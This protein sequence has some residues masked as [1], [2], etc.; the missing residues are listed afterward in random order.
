MPD[1][2]SQQDLP[3]TVCVH[4]A[5]HEMVEYLD[6]PRRPHTFCA[7]LR[8]SEGTS[9]KG[10]DCNAARRSKLAALPS[11]AGVRL[12]HLVDAFVL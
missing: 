11:C 10:C 6:M 4:S 5:Y 1:H 2:G 8:M 9:F 3:N 12:N 7:C